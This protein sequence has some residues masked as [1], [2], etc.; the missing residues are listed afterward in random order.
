MKIIY[1]LLLLSLSCSVAFGQRVLQLEKRNSTKTVKFSIGDEITYKLAGDEDWYKAYIED[2][3]PDDGIVLFNNR[4]V[5]VEN[6]VALRF[7]RN[8]PRPL[9]RQL[10]VFGLGWAV[11]ATLDKLVLDL[12][13][14]NEEASWGFV[15]IPAATAV[16]TGFLIG[17]I[18]KT[19]I[20]KIGNKRRLRLLDL[21]VVPFQNRP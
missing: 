11:F 21:E 6:I 10:Y 14:V 7:D 9:E 5:Q 13:V 15:I 8:W 1:T 19:K 20:I 3:K 4:L 17:K 16:V 2:I 18:F 12:D